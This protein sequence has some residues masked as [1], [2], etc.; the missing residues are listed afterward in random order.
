MRFIWGLGIKRIL[1]RY[2]DWLKSDNLTADQS[3]CCSAV[4]ESL[5]A[6]D[7]MPDARQRRGVIERVY[8]RKSHT[9]LGAAMS[10][11]VSQRT[12]ERYLA[13][14]QRDVGARLNLPDI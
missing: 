5:A 4:S 9:V 8:F 11:G 1:E 7:A 2:P 3:R 10:M 6:V 13:Q 14:Y 12:A